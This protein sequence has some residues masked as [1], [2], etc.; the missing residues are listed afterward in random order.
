M[1][2]ASWHALMDMALQSQKKFGVYI[3][4]DQFEFYPEPD[5]DNRWVEFINRVKELFPEPDSLN[6]L[7]SVLNN[8]LMMFDTEEE[9][10]RLYRIMET[11]YFAD[12][13]YAWI[14]GP[15]GGITENT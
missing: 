2:S 6:I 9:A 14:G 12:Q 5:Y 10:W 15:Q 7:S 1:K 8:D 3:A 13:E 11:P 4:G